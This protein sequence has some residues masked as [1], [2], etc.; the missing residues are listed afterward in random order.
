MAKK[1]TDA[2][3]QTSTA[4]MSFP[5]PP[6][7]KAQEY[8]KAYTSYT[9]TAISAIA[10]EVASIDLK[11]H[12]V[13]HT[14]QGPETV[15][16]PEHESLSFLQYVNPLTTFYDQVEA[17][18]IYLELTGE[19]FWVL[20]KNGG[21]P[22]EMWLVRPDW[23]KIQPDKKEII[24]HYIY[25]PGGSMTEKV[26]IPKENV[27]HFK[28][29]NPLNPYRGKGSVQAAALPLDI[30]TFA[31]EWNRNFFFNSAMPGLVFTTEKKLNEKV[32]KRFIEQWQ[33]SYG[34]RAKSNKIAFLGSGLKL[35]KTT[36][37]AKELDFAA[38]Q[39]LMR[40]DI[41]AVFKVPKS[42]LGLTEDVN[43]ANAEATNKA[44]MERVITPRM[45]KFAGALTEFLLPMYNESSLFFDFTDP[46]PEDVELQ[47]KKYENALKFGWLTPN[48][49]RAE[50]GLEPLEGGDELMPL[51]VGGG[52]TI[53][54][55]INEPDSD[56]D[57]E[58]KLFARL[59]GGK[60]KKKKVKIV[61][62]PKPIPVKHMVK[63]PAKRLE[64]VKRERLE[65]D[66]TKDL[67]KMIGEM[68]KTKSGK[69]EGK[70]EVKFRGK[71]SLLNEEG[72]DAYWKQFINMVTKREEELKEQ[73]IDLFNEQEKWILERLEEVK[74]WKKGLRKGKEAS[75][76]PSV[77]ELS[78]IWR[79][80]F[81]RIIREMVIE[82]GNYTLDF[83]GAGGNLDLLTETSA[84]FLRVH[85]AELVTSI[86]ET[87]RD[88]LRKVL[89]E[90]FT[91]GES[92]P[93][94]RVRVE[95]VFNEATRNRATMIARTE[96]LR[97]SNFATV[98]AYRQSEVVEAKEWLA[99]RDN[100][101]CPYCLEMD[102]KVIGLSESYFKEGDTFTVNG[103]SLSIGL[104]DV[105]EPPLHVQCRCT[106]IPVLLGQRSRMAEK[107]KLE[108][109]LKKEVQT[110]VK[111]KKKVKK[112]KKKKVKA[113]KE[114]EMK[115]DVQPE[116]K[117]KP[118]NILQKASVKIKKILD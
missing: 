33:A 76:I 60:P 77:A 95:N 107:N 13:T 45:T 36:L 61:K 19:A 51:R 99:E 2:P 112:S 8:L 66:L 43:R 42:I 85:G 87:T 20:L 55:P 98:E 104:L 84:T 94:L 26:I 7:R 106:T 102:G 88:Q 79:V 58:E 34:G 53:G 21:V 103:D 31:Q 75:V 40:D 93:K 110:N 62:R 115:K 48:E 118:K 116:T 69:K 12:K 6:L 18:Q 101:T 114:V 57:E 73:V 37:G 24:K 29:F 59:L 92:I 108:K 47:L 25:R 4:V 3:Q 63:I 10:Q 81:I 111:L 17:T 97:A 27:I 113:K 44:F 28:N 90:G 86:N 78:T 70:G 35:D 96:S 89:A 109:A 80:V 16:I 52:N 54:T 30:H 23:M 5:Q 49:V 82:Q 56:N 9:F 117:G 67:T 14:P 46:A 41:L 1:V 65:E 38:Q 100:R 64:V 32:I 105:D 74:H 15:L 72:K 50:E 83:L 91:A 71:D 39:R 22:Q 11:L 68:L